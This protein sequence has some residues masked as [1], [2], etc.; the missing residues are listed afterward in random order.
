M[1][2]IGLLFAVSMA[3][4]AS[5]AEANR[6]RAELFL[7]NLAASHQQLKVYAERAAELATA[8]ERNRLARIYTT[9]WV[10]T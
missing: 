9:A 2:F 8:E 4:I 10:I 6:R 5:E 1:L 3:S 7:G